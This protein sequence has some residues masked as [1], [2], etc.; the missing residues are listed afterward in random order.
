MYV[1][2]CKVNSGKV[3]YS[4]LVLKKKS[5][6][7]EPNSQDTIKETKKILLG[8]GAQTRATSRARNSV[9]SMDLWSSLDNFYSKVISLLFLKFFDLAVYVGGLQLTLSVP[10]PAARACCHGLLPGPVARLGL[11]YDSRCFGS[12]RLT[13]SS[14]ATTS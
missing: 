9:T 14:P 12:G 5:N 10:G 7:Q 2:P 3:N 1:L 4:K 13:T 11:K 6:N 8:Q